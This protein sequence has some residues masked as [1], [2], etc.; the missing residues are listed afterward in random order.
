MTMCREYA[1]DDQFADLTPLG[2]GR[3]HNSYRSLERLII[4]ERGPLEVS[5]VYL[6]L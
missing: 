6:P 1:L 3:C 4:S 5:K 2:A